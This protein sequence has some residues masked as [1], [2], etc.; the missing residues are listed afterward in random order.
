MDWQ[1]QL[2]SLYLQVCKF[3]SQGLSEYCTRTSHYSNLKFSDEEALTLFL[4]GI[5]EGCKTIKSIHKLGKHHLYDWFPN[6]PGYVAFDQRLNHISDVFIPLIE[7]AKD[8][9]STPD[10]T[11]RK[12]DAVI[13]SMPIIMAQRGRRFNAKV[14]PEIATANG[15]CATKKLYYYG[16]KLHILAEHNPGKLPHP[17]YIGLTNAGMHDRKAF[18]MIMPGLGE[19]INNCYADKA[20]QT[21]CKAINES[22]SFT[23]LTPVKKEKGQTNL[24]SADKWLSRAI[25]SI[26]QPIESF[27]NWINE[28]TGIQI[29]SK[30]RSYKGLMVHVF[31][32]LAAAMLIDAV[33]I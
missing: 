8:K 31:G 9:C 7:I 14:A 13:D 1:D 33:K 15:Y 27:F 3:Y 26:R 25:S 21:E 4:W 10:I 19:H 18:E 30:V 16:V 22:E 5:Q 29:A 24:D 11:R 32:R 6:L 20:Y 12:Y 17:E 28:K 23:L 2:I